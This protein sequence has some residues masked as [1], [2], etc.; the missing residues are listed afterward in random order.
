MQA[1]LDLHGTTT[2]ER[3]DADACMHLARRYAGEVQTLAADKGYDRQSLCETLR[4]MGIR[5]LVKHRV[6]APTVH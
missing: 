2:Q 1:I 5:P 4:E 6:F 3:S